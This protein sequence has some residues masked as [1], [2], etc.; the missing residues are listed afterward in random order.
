MEAE[1]GLSSYGR[2]YTPGWEPIHANADIDA[3]ARDPDLVPCFSPLSAQDFAFYRV[4]PH[5]VVLCPPALGGCVVGFSSQGAGPDL[6]PCASG[7]RLVVLDTPGDCNP[8]MEWFW[9]FSQQQT[10]AKKALLAHPAGLPLGLR[11]TKGAE[12]GGRIC[13]ARYA[14][15][16]VPVLSHCR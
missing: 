12:A 7:V 2:R 15:N 10:D 14:V 11:R 16:A 6:Y 4:D 3:D 5:V 9:G 13:C 8:G 1:G